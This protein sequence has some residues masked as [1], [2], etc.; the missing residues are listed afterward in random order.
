MIFKK[1]DENSIVR[2]AP[3]N[4]NSVDIANK[5]LKNE[6]FLL[7]GLQSINFDKGIDWDYKHEI[8]LDTYSLYLHTLDSV[9]Y[10]SSA[11]E[12][13]KDKKYIEK[14][15]SIMASWIDYVKNEKINKMVWYDHTTAF[16]SQNILHF[17]LIAKD[18]I[19]LDSEVYENLIMKH[20]NYLYDDKNYKSYNHG[21]MLDKALL[22]CASVIEGKSA[23]M[24]QSK[25]LNRL[26]DNFYN[27]FSY[28]GVH[29]E[30]SMFYHSFV[31]G[32]Y[33][34]IEK[35]LNT[36]GLSLGSNILIKLKKANNYFNY[37]VKPN[38]ELPA[39]GDN[40]KMEIGNKDK[41]YEDFFD[42]EAGIAYL[43]YEN[44]ENPINSTWL[45][46][47]CGYS[48]TIHKHYDDLSFTLYYGGKDIFVDS[49][50][51]GYGDTKER[52][53]LTSQKAHNTF[54]IE[55][56]SYALVEKEDSFKKIKIT[57]FVTN[58]YYSMVKGKNTSY[59][60]T[61]LYRT[62]ILFKPNIIFIY[63]KGVSK[64]EKEY[65]QLYN[66]APKN[67]VTQLDSR[68]CIINDNVEI[69]QINNEF[70][71]KYYSSN[72]EEPVAVICEKSETLTNTCQITFK[73]KSQNINI[74]TL[75]SLDNSKKNIEN[76]KFDEKN[77]ILYLIINEINYSIAL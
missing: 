8:N 20:I 41:F 25:A 17:Y 12:I 18:I 71:S 30:N 57:D 56:E 7:S 55:N 70:T 40:G 74:L 65:T 52:R 68:T 44:K 51:F 26:K 72:K 63:D 66:V 32:M 15:N 19:F 31:K 35:F 75:I 60:D 23:E 36:I 2:L 77:E 14:A 6:I 43:Q 50:H 29:L 34:E 3:L 76:L 62:L 16:R 73:K 48:S 38:G 59:N 4:N 1:F 9:G 39:I 5:A 28:K 13:T 24:L 22:S 54:L 21:M 58:K 47:I 64:S 42:Y 46:F 49:G 33:E 67:N 69:I 10:L 37:A 27:N 61:K 11:Y 53:Y 45:S